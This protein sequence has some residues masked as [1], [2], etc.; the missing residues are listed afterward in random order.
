MSA[1]AASSQPLVTVGV[2]VRNGGGLLEAAL[3][4]VVRQTWSPLEIIISDNG[5][6]IDTAKQTTLF[7]D[8]AR[9]ER[10]D[11]EG[12]GVGLGIARRLAH[13][14]GARLSLRSKPGQGTR[15]AISFDAPD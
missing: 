14:L 11:G 5:R 6:G 12:L 2:P 7:H 9:R 1:T 13:S 4:S 10:E 15:L 8:F 3:E